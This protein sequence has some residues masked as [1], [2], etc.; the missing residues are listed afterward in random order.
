MLALI[1]LLSKEESIEVHWFQRY[2]IGLRKHS[3]L[4]LSL[5]HRHWR[6]QFLPPVSLAKQVWQWQRKTIIV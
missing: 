5:H 6:L 4:M 3:Q 2:L 1:A